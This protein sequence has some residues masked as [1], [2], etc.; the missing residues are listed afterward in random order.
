MRAIPGIAS[1]LPLPSGRFAEDPRLAWRTADK[2]VESSTEHA[3]GGVGSRSDI[4]EANQSRI[5]TILPNKLNQ[6]L[7]I[8]R[9]SLRIDAVTK[10]E[11][12][13]PAG[14]AIRH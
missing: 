13:R 6:R 12:M 7:N 1:V 8:A 5:W 9:R 3:G 11:Y 14:E 4:S 2:P 10:I